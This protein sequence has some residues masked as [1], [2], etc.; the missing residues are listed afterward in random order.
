MKDNQT[1]VLFI[2]AANVNQDHFITNVAKNLS[3]G[4]GFNEVK[5]FY[6]SETAIITFKS[7]E[8]FED[9]KFQ[10][11]TYFMDYKI[12]FIL[13]PYHPDKTAINMDEEARIHLFG[14][15]KKTENHGMNDIEA[16]VARKLSDDKIFEDTFS[17]MDDML[18]PDDELDL[19]M[20][21]LKTKPKQ[22]TLDELLD[23]INLSGMSS[24]SENE[25]S[26]LKSYSK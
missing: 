26:L 7:N 21:V 5:Y 11:E 8:D 20:L 10:S 23:K 1:Y 13:T 4:L 16:Y 2:F 12:T 6:G 19:D 14:T 3:E 17:M 25:L 24:L 9:I 22:I 15:D 18:D